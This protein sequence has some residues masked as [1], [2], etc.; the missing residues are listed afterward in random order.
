[1]SEYVVTWLSVA[2]EVLVYGG[3]PTQTAALDSVIVRLLPSDC[4]C[5]IIVSLR[6]KLPGSLLE[7]VQCHANS[8]LACLA[9]R[10]SRSATVILSYERTRLPPVRQVRPRFP[11]SCSVAPP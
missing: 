9:V 8:I 10:F 1:M 2:L 4:K 3:L 11:D 6:R 5:C 7:H